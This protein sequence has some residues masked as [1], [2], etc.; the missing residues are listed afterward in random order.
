MD[1]LIVKLDD[2]YCPRID[3]LIGEL[4]GSEIEF[5]KFPPKYLLSLPFI[6][7]Y[8]C[9]LMVLEIWHVHHDKFI[10]SAKILDIFYISEK[11]ET[12][13]MAICGSLLGINELYEHNDILT[14]MDNP[15]YQL[16]ESFLCLYSPERSWKNFNLTLIDNTLTIKYYDQIIFTELIE[17]CE[18]SPKYWSIVIKKLL[19]EIRDGSSKL[20]QYSF[21]RM[22]SAR[23]IEL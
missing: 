9:S 15:L 4:L 22:K 7:R 14:S 16:L 23:K 13:S 20:L 19:A 17:D 5:H 1:Q 8:E 10:S 6:F 11:C 3:E 2:S 21:K 18:F 12:P